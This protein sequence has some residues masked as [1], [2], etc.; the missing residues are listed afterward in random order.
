MLSVGG[1][2]RAGPR[3]VDGIGRRRCRSSAIARVTGS[4]RSTVPGDP[5]LGAAAG[6]LAVDLGVPHDVRDR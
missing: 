5:E 2:R 6:L 1:V 4:S 3:S